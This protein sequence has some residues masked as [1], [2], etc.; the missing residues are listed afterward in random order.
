MIITTLNTG[1]VFY[2]FLLHIQHL[3]SL[4]TVSMATKLSEVACTLEYLSW[5]QVVDFVKNFDL[6]SCD[7]VR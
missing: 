7:F 4:F 5:Q 1:H 6:L 3:Y 2:L